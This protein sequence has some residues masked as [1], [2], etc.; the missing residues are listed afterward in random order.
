MVENS[1]LIIDPL[2][3]SWGIETVNLGV[4]G[5]EPRQRTHGDNVNV[6]RSLRRRAL[7]REGRM[8][9]LQVSSTTHIPS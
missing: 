7:P 9:R 6:G 2:A 3:S 1:S 8:M 5:A 4:R